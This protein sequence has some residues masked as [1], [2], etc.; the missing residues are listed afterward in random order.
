MNVLDVLDQVNVN[1]IWHHDLILV[2][3]F[4]DRHEFLLE[5]ATELP[6]EEIR[7]LAIEMH[8]PQM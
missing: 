2:L 1:A 6:H 3:L 4:D 7:I 5:F 8:L